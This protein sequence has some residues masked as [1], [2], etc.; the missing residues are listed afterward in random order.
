MAQINFKESQFRFTDPIRF[1]K[2]NDPIYYEVENIPLKQ[3]HEN[4]LWLKDQIG[5]GG[6]TNNVTISEIDRSG[7]SELKPYCDGT[8]NVVKVKPGRFTARINDAYNLNKLQIIQSLFG[9]AIQDY[10]SWFAQALPQPAIQ[11]ILES[12]KTAA[13]NMNGLAERAFT[14]PAKEPDRASQFRGSTT[15]TVVTLTGLNKA[16]YPITEAQLWGGSPNG[17]FTYLIRQYNEGT[18]GVGFAALGNA[19]T[20]FIKRWRGI[21]RTAVVD[22][23]EE[24]SLE[25][26]AFDEQDFYYINEMGDKILLPSTQRIDLLFIYSKP[27]DTDYVTLAKFINDTPLN[28]TRPTLGIVYGAGLGIDFSDMNATENTTVENVRAI[29]PDGTMK[30]L[31]SI[32]D[33][34]DANSGFLASSIRG[35][36]PA[37]DD[38][39]NLSPQ[40]DE[41]LGDTDFSLIGQSILPIAY[42]VTKKAAS[43]NDNGLH[44]LTNDNIVDIRPFF[45]TTELSY[46]ERAGIA[47]AVPAPSLANPIVTQS[48][49]DYE[50]KRV[51]NDLL[52]RFTTTTQQQTQEKP[53]VVG[54]GYI[55]GGFNYGVEGT[56]CDYI[57]K[58]VAPTYRGSKER[59]IN[60]F[61]TRYQLPG[62]FNV[63]DYPDWDLAPWVGLNNL[64]EPGLHLNDRIN[65]FQMGM[66]LGGRRWKDRPNAEFAS[67]AASPDIDTRTG[68]ISTTWV[69]PKIERLGTD[70]MYDQDGHVCMMFCKKTIYLNR[71]LVDNWMGDYHVDA[72]LWNCVPLTSRASAR[73]AET[74]AGGS[75][76]WV[77]KNYDNFT[78]YV[79]WQ[80]NDYS[81]GIDHTDRII[82]PGQDRNQ[83]DLTQTRDGRWYSGFVVINQD[84]SN[85]ELN[86]SVRRFSGESNGGITTYPSVT[87]QIIGYPY[88]YGGMGYNLNSISPT[89]SLV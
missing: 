88:G 7:F 43:L 26:P 79:A 22:V 50:V 55:K 19:E 30:I 74:A 77:E 32:G 21:A 51:Y 29:R 47:A 54:G 2:S 80:A 31:P 8:D 87:F 67:Y 39:M 41:T 18:P 89:L 23:S 69:P 59:L 9:D 13:F 85:S 44:T 64:P 34:T 60:E 82:P 70:S 56:I 65:V 63:P 42:I 76:I 38:L 71:A 15:P 61:K 75:Y 25:I 52:S 4:T 14:Y 3:I 20:A 16:P 5:G 49:L 12:F 28:V 48:E 62:E 17:G 46:N 33:E 57:A 37:P 1:F 72:Q 66:A 73:V 53:R 35:S 68:T 81:N 83:I 86:S 45:R 84:I 10:N 6:S 27:I 58:K 11:T 36:F 40:L 78:I 24:L